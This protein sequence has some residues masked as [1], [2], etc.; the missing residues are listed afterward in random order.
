MGFSS[1]QKI[2][3]KIGWFSSWIAVVVFVLYAITLL[4]GGVIYGLPVEPFFIIAEILTILG[5]IVLVLL[6]GCIHYRMSG[7]RRL[8][9]FL[10][11]G[12]MFVMAGITIMVHMAEL[13]VARQLNTSVRTAFASVYDF[14]WPSLLYG[15]EFVAWHIGFGLSVLFASFAFKKVGKENRIRMGLRWVGIFC[16]AGLI[17]PATGNLYWRLVGVFGYAIL[18]PVVCIPIAGIFRKEWLAVDHENTIQS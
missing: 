5:A 11:T 15:I 8:F 13:T 12:W 7:H 9:T 16:L 17:G 18:F 6:M 3:L 14:E 4:A 2:I 10:G 1:E